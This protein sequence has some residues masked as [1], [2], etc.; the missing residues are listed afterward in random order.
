MNAVT[1]AWTLVPGATTY[2]IKRNVIPSEAGAVTIGPSPTNS[3][4]D[5]AAPDNKTSYYYV[6]ATQFGTSRLVGTDSGFARCT[7][8]MN[9]DNVVNDADFVFFLAAYNI[10][11]CQA[12]GMPA[13]CPAD[14]NYDGLVDDADF[15]LF[16]VAYDNLV[17]P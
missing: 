8:D 6:Y 3:Y 7:A 17:C 13:G 12:P 4:I 15:S 14:F 10:F 16:V 5:L 2:T 9:N 1:L 11:D